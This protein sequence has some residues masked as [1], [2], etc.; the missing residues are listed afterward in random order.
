M[1]ADPGFDVH[2]LLALRVFLPAAKYDA[3]H[4]VAFEQQATDR[5]AALPG[6]RSVAAGSI[7]PLFYSLSM[8]VRFEPEGSPPPS[9]M[10]PS[11]SY[12]SVGDDYFRT[13]DIPLRRGRFFTRADDRKA[14][15]VVLVNESFAARFYPGRDPTGQ[16]IQL[17]R[18]LRG[19]EETANV[20]VAGVVGDVKWT[21]MSPGPLPTIYAPLAQNLFSGGVWFAVRTAS[22]P[23]GLAPAV[24]KEFAA[25]D[26]EEP[27]EQVGT[28]EAMVNSQFAQ[29]QFQTWVMMAFALMALL[30]ASVGIYGVNAYA[31][32]QRRGEIGLRMA[33]GASRGDVLRE[34]MARGLLPAAAGIG[35]GLA[36]SAAMMFWLK[37]VL[38]GAG[39]AD[40]LAFVGAALLLTLAALAACYLPARRATRIDPSI[41]LRAE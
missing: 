37:S 23:L 34:V 36:A 15:Q 16:R 39:K 14:P 11:A 8:K 9:E 33:L 32:A 26:P 40:P 22:D 2:H 41:T 24:R 18:P 4:A 5:V 1:R 25:L 21:D 6:V 17:D 13:Y 35:V 10:S 29:P 3:A 38:V 28:L 30:L 12:F 20:Q 27:V 31:V 19:G 7:L